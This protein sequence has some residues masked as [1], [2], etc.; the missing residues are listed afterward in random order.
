MD[1]RKP[2][3]PSLYIAIVVYAICIVHADAC[4]FFPVTQQ[5]TCFIRGARHQPK[6]VCKILNPTNFSQR[7]HLPKTLDSTWDSKEFV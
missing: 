2:L 3:N 5:D 6:I 4:E 7:F 1:S